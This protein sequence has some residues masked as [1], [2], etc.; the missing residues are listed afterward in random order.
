MKKL[1]LGREGLTKVTRMTFKCWRRANCYA[2]KYCYAKCSDCLWDRNAH[3]EGWLRV[4]R[5]GLCNSSYF[6]YIK[7]TTS[8]QEWCHKAAYV[9]RKDHCFVVLDNFLAWTTSLAIT[10]VR[11][12]WWANPVPIC[13]VICSRLLYDCKTW[14][15]LDN[16]FFRDSQPM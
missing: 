16:I 1:Y 13:D 12:S 15:S 11:T 9:I 4:N 5:F 3:M 10:L 6:T 14:C 7:T 2:S 8:H